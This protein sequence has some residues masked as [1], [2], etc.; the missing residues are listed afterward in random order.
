VGYDQKMYFDKKICK[1]NKLGKKIMQ[2]FVSMCTSG[3]TTDCAWAYVRKHVRI[4]AAA[5]GEEP[6]AFALGT[7]PTRSTRQARRHPE[8]AT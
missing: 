1:W 4:Q 3:L 8:H 7:H 5:R 2:R 6:G